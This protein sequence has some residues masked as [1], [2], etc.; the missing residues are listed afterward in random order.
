MVKNMATLDRLLRIVIALSIFG[1]WAAGQI[2][3][4]AAIIL[5]SLAV[6]FIFTSSVGFCPIYRALGVSTRKH[7]N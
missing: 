4:V 1:L 7:P 6:V 2:T 3:G 5:G